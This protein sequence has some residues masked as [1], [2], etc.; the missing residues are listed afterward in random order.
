MIEKVAWAYRDWDDGSNLSFFI[1][2]IKNVKQV[3]KTQ[4]TK[5]KFWIEMGKAP[6]YYKQPWLLDC[7]EKNL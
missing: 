5:P 4:E 7:E 6:K 1:I 3:Q 2:I